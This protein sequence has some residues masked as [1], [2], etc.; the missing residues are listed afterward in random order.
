MTEPEQFIDV[1]ESLTKAFAAGVESV[2]KG[3]IVKAWA[4]VGS[5]RGI[6]VFESGP[7]GDRYPHLLHI[8]A[9]QVTPD[10]IPVHII[11]PEEK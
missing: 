9:K 1:T 8:F 6:F 10:L 11:I 3:K 4:D 7:V 5:H 2:Q